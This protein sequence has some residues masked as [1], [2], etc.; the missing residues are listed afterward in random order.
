MEINTNQ[1]LSCPKCGNSSFELIREATYLY[2][3]EIDSL[4]KETWLNKTEAFP[5][6]FYNR[7]QIKE[8]ENLKCKKCSTTYPCSLNKDNNEMKLIILQKALRSDS[9]DIPQFL[10]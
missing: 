5:F 10:G 3:Y 4:E 8:E 9:Q 6:L 1:T 2:T 7:E